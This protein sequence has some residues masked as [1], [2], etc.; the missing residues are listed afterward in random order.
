VYCHTVGS[1]SNA[2]LTFLYVF[3]KIHERLLLLTSYTTCIQNNQWRI[4]GGDGATPPLL[5]PDREF[6]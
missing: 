6:F 4:H 3:R 1:D 2:S 5:W